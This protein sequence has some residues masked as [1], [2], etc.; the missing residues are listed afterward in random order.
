MSDLPPDRT[1][2]ANP[3]EFTTLD[4]FGPYKVR[5]EVRKRVTVKVWGIVFCCM[6]SRAIYTDVVS[7]QSSEGFLLAYQ[8]FTSLRGHPK[9]LWSDPGTNFVGAKPALE[10]LHRIMEK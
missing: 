7:D 4:L 8:R 10:E 6:A 2:P 1:S 9:K 3:F 5:D